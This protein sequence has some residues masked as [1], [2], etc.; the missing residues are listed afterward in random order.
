MKTQLSFKL[1]KNVKGA[2]VGDLYHDGRAILATT[3]PATIAAAIF[4]MNEKMFVFESSL[5]KGKFKFPLVD[6]ELQKIASL[7]KDQDEAN[8]MSAFATFSHFDFKQPHPF[9]TQADIH[10][11]VA[12]HHLAPE[13]VKVVPL[14]PVRKGF[15]KELRNRNKYVYWPIC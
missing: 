12:I 5:G 6:N 10:L 8:H 14:V 13:L 7:L 1:Y 9:D 11:R 4:A 15:K 2:V 3:H